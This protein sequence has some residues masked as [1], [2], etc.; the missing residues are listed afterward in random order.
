M[1]YWLQLTLKIH[2]APR[3][4]PTRVMKR[5]LLATILLFGYVVSFA[6]TESEPNNTFTTANAVSANVNTSATVG[7]ADAIDNF[8]ASFVFNANFRVIIQAT[9]TSGS[10]QVLTFKFYNGLTF[11]GP[12]LSPQLQHTETVSSAPIGAGQTKTDTIEVCG[13]APDTYYMTLES[14]G[15]FNYTLRWFPLNS[16][17]ID[18]GNNTMSTA[19]PFTYNVLKQGSLGYEFWGNVNID[20]ANYFKSILPVGDYSTR[21]LYINAQFNGC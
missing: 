10:P 4:E 18:G 9:N 8:K 16:V 12:V 17:T 19:R 13:L 1:D 20:S 21:R 11:P 5:I 6:Q 3:Y 14:P 2:S 7:G 15:T